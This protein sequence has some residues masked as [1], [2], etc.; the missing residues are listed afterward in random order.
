MSLAMPRSERATELAQFERSEFF[1][2]D[3]LHVKPQVRHELNEQSLQGLA[4]SLAEVGQLQPI[5]VRLEDGKY[6]IVDGER[7]FQAAQIA[8]LQGLNGVVET[9]SL[10][11]GDILLQQLIANIQRDDLQPLEKAAGFQRLMSA[12]G[13][14]ASDVAMKSGV[15]NGTVT[16]LLAL[17]TLPEPIR[18]QVASGAIPASAAY[19]LSR[20]EDAGRQAEL[21]KQVASGMRRDALAG[22]L[23][24]AKR[25]KGGASSKGVSRVTA[26]LGMNKSVTVIGPMVTLDDAIVLLEDCLAKA[27]Q[28][29]TRGISLS[30]FVRLC[31]ETSVA[32]HA[33]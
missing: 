12:T 13:W 22:A 7:R 6:F 20:I 28:G 24:S 2:L 11:E 30:T 26:V 19:E 5:R 16:R 33:T 27:R 3:Q 32:A 23:K 18:D 29:R 21:A 4:T 10:S 15:S 14:T 9:R 25:S 1:T 8:N 31:K 17:L